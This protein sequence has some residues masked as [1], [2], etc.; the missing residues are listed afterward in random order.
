[1]TVYENH[2]KHLPSSS[3]SLQT[4]DNGEENDIVESPA[5]PSSADLAAERRSPGIT[6]VKDGNPKLIQ[7][8]FSKKQLH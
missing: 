8:S 3:E 7:V 1:M 2:N 4:A 5:H 6:H